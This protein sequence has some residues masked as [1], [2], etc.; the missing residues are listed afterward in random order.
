MDQNPW[1]GQNTSHPG[2]FP[3]FAL[4]SVQQAAPIMRPRLVHHMRMGSDIRLEAF[5]VVLLKEME[6]PHWVS[7]VG[8]GDRGGSGLLWLRRRVS[9]LLLLRGGDR[10]GGSLLL[11]RRPLVDRGGGLVLGC[12]RRVA[13]LLLLLHHFDPVG[14]LWGREVGK[15]GWGG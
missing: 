14:V 9:L 10:R 3:P 11:L 13:F 12:R 2:P 8:R 6:C 5:F 1:R 15:C 4:T 7:L